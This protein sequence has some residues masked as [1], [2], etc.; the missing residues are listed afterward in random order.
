MKKIICI[1]LIATM[2]V[3]GFA[4]CNCNASAIEDNRFE[5]LLYSDHMGAY[6]IVYYRDVKTDVIYMFTSDMDCG[7]IC[8]LYNADGTPILYDEFMASMEEK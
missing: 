4:G 6:K 2:A 7:G 1:L 8:P 5:K 3:I